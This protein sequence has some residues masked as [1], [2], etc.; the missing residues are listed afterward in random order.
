MRMTK[1]DKE[2]S[3]SDIRYLIASSKLKLKIPG[4]IEIKQRIL[5]SNLP[6]QERI[7]WAQKIINYKGKK[8]EN[9]EWLTIT[10][11]SREVALN[12]IRNKSERVSG[13]NNPGYNHKGK[14]SVYSKN[15][16]NYDSNKAQITAQK[17]RDAQLNGSSHRTVQYWMNK[18][19]NEE[20]AKEAVKDVQRTF[21]L[22]KC[23]DKH[24]EEPFN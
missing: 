15:N 13:K 4:R 12:K 7:R 2:L 5:L 1:L 6:W 14:F 22:E 19:L 9:L 16:P 24:G 11:N 17:N 8:G 3:Y 18:G 10:N 20:E 21:T 23:I